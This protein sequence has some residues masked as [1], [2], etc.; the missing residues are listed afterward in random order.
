MAPAADPVPRA[1]LRLL[2]AG[3]AAGAVAVACEAP[4]VDLALTLIRA[5]LDAV[6]GTFRTI[7]LRAVPQGGEL[8]IA[9]VA[10]PAITQVLGT[11]VITPDPAILLSTAVSGGLVLQPLVLMTAL[12]AA[13]PWQRP[14]E[15]ALRAVLAAPLA[16]LVLALDVPLMLYG[17]LWYQEV[18]AF[19]PERFSPLVLWTDFVNAG[20]RHALALAAAALA[21]AGARGILTGLPSPVPPGRPATAL[22]AAP[23]SL[24]AD[25]A[26]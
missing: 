14:A 23:P 21:V 6:D 26:A 24:P 20:G 18:S 13:W 19:E 9:R 15:L 17:L 11:R 22:P 1:L 10:T 8:M 4:L 2:L 5:C 3:L 12:L 25:R 7:A 16:L